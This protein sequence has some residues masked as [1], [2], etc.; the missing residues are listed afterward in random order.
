MKNNFDIPEN[1]IK[2]IAD[3]AEKCGAKKVIL[4]GSR[5]RGTNG[6]RSDID[7]AVT[8]GDFGEFC[9]AMDEQVNTLLMFDVVDLNS[10]KSAE[11]ISEIERDGVVLYEKI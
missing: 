2:E 11:L 3:N 10:C 6:E 8:G 5:A 9:F 7:L 1:V 4:F